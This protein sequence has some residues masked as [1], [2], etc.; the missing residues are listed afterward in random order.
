MLADGKNIKAVWNI[1][2][3]FSVFQ[4]L[5]GIDVMYKLFVK[6]HRVISVIILKVLPLN[7]AVNRGIFRIEA[8][9]RTVIAVRIC[10]QCR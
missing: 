8:N 5:F 1:G 9:E 4:H 3:G 7:V 6:G 2:P 10:A